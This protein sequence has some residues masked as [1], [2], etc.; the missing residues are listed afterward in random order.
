[1]A[2]GLATRLRRAPARRL[3]A[4]CAAGAVRDPRQ[5]PG[6]RAADPHRC[7]AL[8]DRRAGHA[9]GADG[10]RDRPRCAP[11]HGR[12]G[13]RGAASCPRPAVRAGG[14]RRAGRDGRRRTRRECRATTGGGRGRR[15]GPSLT[16]PHRAD[17]LRAPRRPDAARRRRRVSRL[18]PPGR[19]ARRHDRPGDPARRAVRGAGRGADPR[20]AAGEAGPD[21][22]GERRRDDRPAPCARVRLGD[23]PGARR[24]HRPRGHGDGD[25]RRAADRRPAGGSRPMGL[26][27]RWS[28]RGGRAGHRGG[29]ASDDP[30][31]GHRSQLSRGRDARRRPVPRGPARVPL[32]VRHDPLGEPV[33]RRSRGPAAGAPDPEGGSPPLVRGGPA[34]L[35]RGADRARAAPPAARHARPP[36]DD[37]QPRLAAGVLFPAYGS[38]VVRAGR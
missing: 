16:H 23:R 15:C 27:R 19:G 11:Q 24:R 6:A 34:L 9:R 28:P 10:P 38:L 5:R 3:P 20:R 17:D 32:G 26:A 2:R 4:G 35:P 31:G 18:V 22:L 21:R 8:P 25:V 29:P 13:P 7:G 37:L 1:M 30:H 12:R 14:V 33:R 36:P